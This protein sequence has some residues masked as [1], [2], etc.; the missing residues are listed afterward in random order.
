MR[1][2]NGLRWPLE[3]LPSLSSSHWLGGF[4][5]SLNLFDEIHDVERSGNPFCE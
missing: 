3:M 5:Y 2:E 4:I 1:V